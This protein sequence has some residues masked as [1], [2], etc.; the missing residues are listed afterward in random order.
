MNLNCLACTLIP[1]TDSYREHNLHE[2][3]AK[4]RALVARSW[5][6]AMVL[7]DDSRQQCHDQQKKTKG[8]LA[9]IKADHRRIHS[10]SDVSFPGSP[11]PRL[12]R[13]CG[14]RRNWSFEELTS[15]Y[16]DNRVEIH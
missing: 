9:K 1:R 12:V 15:Q 7:P 16:L 11:E 10:A 2:R 3:A 8:P 13:S 6:G 4:L 14:V 5:S